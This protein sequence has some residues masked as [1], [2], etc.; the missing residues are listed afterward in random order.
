M[1]SVEIKPSSKKLAE[2][3]TSIARG[4]IDMLAEH[5]K[6]RLQRDTKDADIKDISV[7]IIKNS[8]GVSIAVAGGKN[9]KKDKVIDAIN[10]LMAELGK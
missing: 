1:I 2:G 4:N 7:E 3:L 10:R 6:R 9:L 8:D 5:I